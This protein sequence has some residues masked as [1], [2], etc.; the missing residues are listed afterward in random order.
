MVT[1]NENA[2]L[3]RDL[4]RKLSTVIVAS[5]TSRS[6]KTVGRHR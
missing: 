3:P 1:V 4:I 6:V 2:F 5:Q